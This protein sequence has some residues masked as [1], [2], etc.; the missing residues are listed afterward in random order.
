MQGIFDK[1]LSWHESCDAQGKTQHKRRQIM[2][3]LILCALFAFDS[4][5]DYP[6]FLGYR[7]GYYPWGD[8]QRM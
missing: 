7:C 3:G 6:S 8:P 5:N 1:W 2:R 4:W